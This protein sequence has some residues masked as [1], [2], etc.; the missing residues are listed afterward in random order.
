MTYVNCLCQVC[1]SCIDSPAM[2]F[3]L[4]ISSVWEAGPE[5]FIFEEKTIQVRSDPGMGTREPKLGK[6]GYISQFYENGI[7]W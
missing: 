6:E 5:Q 3:G 7:C 1:G 2:V 4:F